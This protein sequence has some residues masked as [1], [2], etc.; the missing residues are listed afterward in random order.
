[1]L[2][3]HLYAEEGAEWLETKLWVVACITIID[4]Y[5]FLALT[6]ACMNTEEIELFFELTSS[7]ISCWSS[8]TLAASAVT[9]N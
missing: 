5:R 1:M 6:S 7:F 9:G 8:S 3:S 4:K 2:E